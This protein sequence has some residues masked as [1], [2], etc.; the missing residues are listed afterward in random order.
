LPQGQARMI[1]EARQTLGSRWQDGPIDARKWLALI[2]ARHDDD[3]LVESVLSGWYALVAVRDI[4]K[5]AEWNSPEE[6]LNKRRSLLRNAVE[7]LERDIV[8]GAD[9]NKC[10]T[11][12]ETSRTEL[13]ATLLELERVQTKLAE[14]Q[15][16]QHFVTHHLP[17]ASPPEWVRDALQCGFA[18]RWPLGKQIDEDERRGPS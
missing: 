2:M 10:G 1:S 8:G 13:E 11:S 5:Q 4:L 16:L 18:E 15:A 9:R 14:R 7:R 3:F 12:L 17:G 6:D